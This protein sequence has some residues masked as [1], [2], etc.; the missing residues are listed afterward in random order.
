MIT[1]QGKDGIL[2]STCYLEASSFAPT[3]LSLPQWFKLYLK[4]FFDGPLRTAAAAT[5]GGSV[6]AYVPSIYINLLH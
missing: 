2:H 4:S 6:Q 1:R 3:T 5:L